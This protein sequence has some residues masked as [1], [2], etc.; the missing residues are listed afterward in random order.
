MVLWCLLMGSVVLPL[1]HLPEDWTVWQKPQLT[2]KPTQMEPLLAVDARQ[3]EAMHST[4][5][6]HAEAVTMPVSTPIDYARVLFFVYLSGVIMMG[7][8]LLVQVLS[9]LK[10][11]RKARIEKRDGYRLAICQGGLSPFAF[12]SV[13]FIPESLYATPEFEL[14]L[15]HEL[16]H[17]RQRHTLDLLLAELTLIWQWFNP[18]AWLYRRL[19]E[20]N[21]EYLADRNVLQQ[22][23]DKKRYQ[24]SLLSWVNGEHVNTLSTSYSFSLIKQRIL[25]MNQKPSPRTY[26][27]RYALIGILLPSL[28][29]FNRPITP[30][31]S[32]VTNKDYSLNTIEA[33]RFSQ[34]Q[35]L[36]VNKPQLDPTKAAQPP[37][38]SPNKIRPAVLPTSSLSNVR[39]PFYI[40]IGNNTTEKDL[41]KLK[42]VPILEGHRIEYEKENGVIHTIRIVT[43]T[44]SCGIQRAEWTGELPGM[45]EISGK[46]GC[47]AGPSVQD[48]NFLLSANWDS[49]RVYATGFKVTKRYIS[50][51]IPKAVA[52]QE[53]AIKNRLKAL[54]NMNWV[55]ER[56]HGSTQIIKFDEPNKQYLRNQVQK[57]ITEN[58]QLVI[59]INDGEPQTNLPVLEEL[60]L[61]QILIREKHQYSYEP[62]TLNLINVK[63]IGLKLDIYTE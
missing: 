8:R 21:L 50:K 22:H 39:L 12:G 24:L 18:G 54:E 48:F 10:L 41:E 26:A 34:K 55:D 25:M 63:W 4:T 38:P 7:L 15:T 45:L 1:I 62:G 57:C 61:K 47:G 43:N 44:G 56:E 17:V 3:P 40:L 32:I 58:K 30:P 37:V 52:L 16:A 13:I 11:Y 28:P 36:R 19:L 9:L 29:M 31:E 5:P 42:K 51:I 46:G 2:L 60:K 6:A 53:N 59:R 23:A 27:L 35:T 33:T 20:V 14:V 49:I